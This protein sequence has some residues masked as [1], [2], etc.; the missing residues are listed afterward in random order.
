MSA[1]RVRSDYAQ[2][3][4]IAQTFGTAAAQ[5]RALL[6]QLTQAKNVL[7]GGEWLGLGANKFYT[8]LE[9]LVFPALQRLIDSLQQT[10]QATTQMSQ[11]LK[12]AEADAAACFRLSAS[13]GDSDRNGGGSSGGVS[14]NDSGAGLHARGSAT[15]G[16][17][18][19][20]QTPLIIFQAEKGQMWTG[21]EQVAV[22]R[23][24]RATAIA[25]MNTI[26]TN[27]HKL[28]QLGELERYHPLSADEAFHLVYGGP[29]TFT[30][31]AESNPGTY[32]HTT[33]T[34]YG[35]KVYST[36]RPQQVTERV[37]VHELGHAFNNAVGKQAQ[38]V[39]ARLSR[40]IIE[41]VDAEGNVTYKLAHNSD[42][43]DFFGYAGPFDEWQ[44]G[45]GTE[46]PGSEEFADM[47][48]G[49]VYGRW[50]DG[51]EG[52]ARKNYMNQTMDKFLNDMQP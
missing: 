35:I 28:W 12:Q 22:A 8:E 16:V 41:K 39:P 34:E 20:A 32:M 49:W 52:I 43:G 19:V 10:Q 47:Y 33:Q 36:T 44:F 46:M 14:I 1:P 50:Y 30:R 7:Q 31:V 38:N 51:E 23:G 5:H 29:L 13:D 21:P 15:L 2:L 6:H 45:F 26:N 24:I 3:A 48:L 25:L 27:N 37:V 11:V 42:A 9:I 17:S 40:P 18:V 4:Q